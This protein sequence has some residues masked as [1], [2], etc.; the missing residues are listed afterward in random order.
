MKP[1]NLSFTDAASIPYAGLTVWSALS[2]IG[3]LRESNAAGKKFLVLGGTGGIGVT[4]IQLLKSWG[5][6]VTATCSNDASEWLKQQ[7]GVDH[8]IDYKTNELNQ[9][10]NNFDMLL[11]A[12]PIHDGID[13]VALNSLKR[14][15]KYLTL[16]IPILS[17][18]DTDGLLLGPLKLACKAACN[19]VEGTKTSRPVVW[20]FFQ[21]SQSGLQQLRQLVEKGNLKPVIQTVF[22]FDT[23]PD[24]YKHARAGHSRGKTVI[25]ME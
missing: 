7:T 2:S 15:G 3:G 6:E 11:D 16:N 14:G 12:T 8:C 4:A 5:V 17:T 24:C 19:V 13:E 22:P 9:I 18:L 23:L 25:S 20:T 21:P 1:K 10:V